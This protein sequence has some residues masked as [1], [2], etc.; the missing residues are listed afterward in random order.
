MLTAKDIERELGLLIPE[1]ERRKNLGMFTPDEEREADQRL[2]ALRLE[3]ECLHAAED[4]L[5]F[6]EN[7]VYIT[8]KEKGL[9][10]LKPN[11]LHKRCITACSI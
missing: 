6:I 9:I 8:T 7:F 11:V 2:R 5:W 10:L 1:Y 4:D 3:Y